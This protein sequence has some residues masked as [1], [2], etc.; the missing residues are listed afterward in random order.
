MAQFL[1]ALMIFSFGISWP[2]NIIKS[3]KS[4]TARGKS[5][6]FLIFILFGYCC[7][8]AGKIIGN[9]INYAF[10]FYILNAV[11]VII[12]IILYFRN[13]ALDSQTNR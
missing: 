13:C 9:A 8:I 3:Y 11:M 7:G 12:D 5:L 4:R 2:T 1:E 6:L 10:A